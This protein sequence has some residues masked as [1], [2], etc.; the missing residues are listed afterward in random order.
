MPYPKMKSPDVESAPTSPEEAARLMRLATY[1][2]IAVAIT[3]VVAKTIAWAMTDSVVLLATLI[4][5]VLDGFASLINLFAVRHAITPADKEHR[6]GHGK[7]EALAGL[8]QSAFIAGSAGFLL[9]ESG[10]RLLDP[11]PLQSYG[12]GLVVMMFS[13]A[14]TLALMTF[15][16]HVIRKTNST[17]IKADALHYRTDFLVNVSVIVALVLSVEGWGG[18]DAVFAIGIAIYILYSSW[19]IVQQS[20]DDLMDRELPGE[21]REAIRKI[22][23]AHAQVRGLHD[24]RSR[25]SGIATFIQLHLE[26][27]DDLTLLQGHVISDEVELQLQTSYPAA[28]III[29]VDPASVVP[30]EPVPAFLQD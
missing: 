28:E 27:D 23:L 8:G 6:F 11:V 2:S 20:L 16:R 3:L 10:R 5:S 1:A 18:F 15:Q 7:A 9:L 13:I 24:L 17:A 19:E 14:A 26:L 29:H 30:H 21:E 25:R 22:A 12:A 4:D